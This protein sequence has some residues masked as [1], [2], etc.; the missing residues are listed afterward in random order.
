MRNIGL[1]SIEAKNRLQLFGSNEIKDVNKKTWY[2]ILFRQIKSNF[3]VYLLFIATILSFFVGKTVTGYTLIGVIFLIIIVG[4]VQEYKAEKA[5]N[6]LK[7]M[8][9]AT[10]IVIRD[11]KEKEIL[12]KDIV[13]G[14]I[15]LLRI[16]EKIPADAAIIEQNNLLVNE[17]ILT[18]ESKEVKKI[19]A[20]TEDIYDDENIVFMGT[21]V[22]NGKCTAK[23]THTGMN[24]KFGKIA[25]LIS[26]TEKEMPLQKKINKICKYMA[27]IGFSFSVIA[28]ILVLLN[29]PIITKAVLIDVLI[30]VIAVS[31]SSFPQG[32]PVVLISALS[33][34]A[35]KM[36]KKNA[37]V[38][39][40]SIIETLGETTVICSDKTGTITKGEM[41]VKK[42]YTND[43]HIDVSG[44][45]Y[46]RHG[47]F[48]S[49]NKKIKDIKHI[50]SLELLIKSAVLC[51]NSFVKEI[52]NDN[53]KIN[54]T[55][56]E[57]ALLVLGAKAN[58][59][60]EDYNAEI[61][62]E[63]PFCSDRKI[64]SVVSLE[65]NKKTVYVKGAPE[66]LINKCTQI[67]KNGIV[68]KLTER[69]IKTLLEINQ[70]LNKE[71][72][73]TLALAYKPY[74]GKELEKD[75]IFLGLVGLEDPPRKEV[76][77]TIKL[78]ME[79]GIKVKMI[80]GDNKD[81]A[82]SIAKQVGL[83]Y[84]G[85][86]MGQDIDDMSD[87]ELKYII[88]SITIFAR[89]RPEHKLRIVKALK[90][91]GEI[92][93]MTGDGVNDA[94]ALKEAQIGVAMGKSGTDVSR[95]VADLILK[96]DNFATIVFAV[97]EGRTIFANM[98]KFTSYQ[99][100]C[101]MA[102]LFIIIVGV[103]IAFKFGWGIPL[104]LPLHILFMNMVTDNLPAITLG[105]NP[106]S[107]D[108]MEERP[109]KKEILTKN[110][111]ILFIF[112]GFLMGLFVL[113][114]YYVSFNVFG[115]EM[116]K[117]RTIALVAL[118]VIEIFAAYIYR[119]FRKPTLTRSP[120]VN[121]YL[122]FASGASIIATI[123]ILYTPV[124]KIFD[125]VPL[126]IIEWL[127]IAIMGFVFLIIFDVLKAINHKKRFWS[128]E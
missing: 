84:K 14:D 3:V 98:R 117:A 65:D 124:S 24:T 106:S 97:K 38:S 120:F 63:V 30:L 122:F 57:A 9:E 107:K 96:D 49:D 40:I 125:T 27:I 11:G 33:F 23:V 37:I 99:L 4:F 74:D 16:G 72:Y 60:K 112:S 78:C 58:L 20:R 111:I 121:K 100:S 118:I 28:G 34:G 93:T 95:S 70:D 41:T 73:R 87:E 18:G 32:F 102:E 62:D 59:F 68:Q 79:S 25:R 76:K 75:L 82:I 77:E 90:A 31:V 42:I 21:F 48:I 114:T 36:A 69:E 7:K 2:E 22:T 116:V 53:Y 13:P 91:N 35:Y 71:T 45:G 47:D 92:V 83:D 109:K 103:A 26:S 119:S 29:S 17:A 43:K 55:P 110:L 101:N 126:R 128:I 86:L 85:L 5:I 51:N 89:V 81:T 80:T 46:E 94:P 12:S 15:L 105:F 108:I 19:E 44:S 54:G 67:Y 8:I 10:S 61:I 127:P 123:I 115:Y 50:K 66:I 64:M 6:A 104:L 56:T 39:R 88:D 113:A 52:E 1:T